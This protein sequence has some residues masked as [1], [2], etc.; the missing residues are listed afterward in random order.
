MM[1]EILMIWKENLNTGHLCL[2]KSLIQSEEKHSCISLF[3][4]VIESKSDNSDAYTL[5]VL[6]TISVGNLVFRGHDLAVTS[7]K[8]ISFWCANVVK[9]LSLEVE[10]IN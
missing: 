8:A 9:A 4:A 5:L 3:Q 10:Y 1:F 7:E 2:A 6:R